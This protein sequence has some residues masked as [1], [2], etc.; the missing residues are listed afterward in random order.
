MTSKTLTRRIAAVAVAAIAAVGVTAPMAHAAPQPATG[1]T[2]SAAL[3]DA[4]CPTN[5]TECHIDI[6]LNAASPTSGAYC[7]SFTSDGGSCQGPTYGTA[8]WGESGFF[9]QYG[10]GTR[11]EW[12]SQGPVRNV[13]YIAKANF[14]RTDAEID[15]R[16]PD[17]GSAVFDVSDAYRHGEDV[18][19]KT[20]ST[21]GAPG[22][23]GGPL[24]I[25]YEHKFVGSSI[26]IFGWMVR[27]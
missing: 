11:F 1:Q 2:P 27:K 12:G 23:K 22:T 9:P 18:H 7:D 25:D 10:I 8:G 15:G 16:V 5:G 26:H 19:W 6:T 21:G 4:D 14:T 17:P 20:V 13:R 3:S 24:Y